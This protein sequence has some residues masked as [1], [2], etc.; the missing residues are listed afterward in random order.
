[1]Y[2]HVYMFE[3]LS[4]GWIPASDAMNNTLYIKHL[5]SAAYT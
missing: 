4:R 2:K 3:I 5:F 1:M